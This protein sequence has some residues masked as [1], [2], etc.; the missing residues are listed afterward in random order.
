MDMTLLKISIKRFGEKLILP[1]F[2]LTFLLC[3]NSL[4][5]A[6]AGRINGEFLNDHDRGRYRIFTDSLKL[7][8][9]TSGI[10]L[11]SRGNGKGGGCSAVAVDKLWIATSAHCIIGAKSAIFYRGDARLYSVIGAVINKRFDPLRYYWKPGCFE[12]PCKNDYPTK[13]QFDIAILRVN[14]IMQGPIAKLSSNLDNSPF[15][16][17]F[18]GWGDKGDGAT[19]EISSVKVPGLQLLRLKSHMSNDQILATLER[20]FQEDSLGGQNIFTLI[21]NSFYSSDLDKMNDATQTNPN[22]N[23]DNKP[24]IMYEYQAGSGDSGSGLFNTE[25]GEL[26]G[27]IAGGGYGNKIVNPSEQRSYSP[28]AYGSLD[29]I[30]PI[31]IHRNWIQGTISINAN[32]VYR[33]IAYLPTGAE[34]RVISLDDGLGKERNTASITDK[35][36]VYEI[37]TVEDSLPPSS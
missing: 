18:M 19:D 17:S 14:E 7:N 24:G 28:G 20:S 25:T 30:T 35:I 15:V 37:E 11:L 16:G 21:G 6:S 13:A 31:A 36:F 34:L 32:R 29:F 3:F 22:Y 10:L 27:V 5:P 9:S 2:I 8:K 4:S 23:T 1:V 12:Y 33:K 26:V